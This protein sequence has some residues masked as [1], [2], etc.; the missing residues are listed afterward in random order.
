[1][2]V[3]PVLDFDATAGRVSHRSANRLLAHVEAEDLGVDWIIETHVHADHLSAAAWLK[4]KVGGKVA[5]GRHVV[6]VQRRFGGIFGSDCDGEEPFDLFLE[7]GQ[8]IALGRISAHALHVP[9][10]TPADM[11]VV[12]GDVVLTGDTLFMPDFGTARADFPG[13][14]AGQL[15]RSIRRLLSLPAATR[16]LHCHDY[17]PPSRGEA[18][19]TS[20]VAEQR[21]TNIHVHD[22]VSEEAFVAMRRERDASLAMPS[23]MLASIQ[24][25]IRGGALPAPASNGHRYLKIPIDAL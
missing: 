3:D 5:M 2:I 1:M 23:L 11:A 19:W 24:V 4:G 18:A 17:P 9:G 13:G 8:G 7:D 14:D 22:G 12:V 6:D 15:Y 25:N 10:H 20:T 21:A 16:L